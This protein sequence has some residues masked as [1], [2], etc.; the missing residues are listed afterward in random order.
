MLCFSIDDL[1]RDSDS[2]DEGDSKQKQKGSKE[3]KT[4]GRKKGS[5]WLKEGQAGSKDDIV[6]FLDPSVSKRVLGE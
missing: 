4:E 5:A 1:L 3:K 2:E 6:D